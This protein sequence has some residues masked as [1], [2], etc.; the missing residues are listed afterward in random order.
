MK[1]LRSTRVRSKPDAGSRSEIHLS[2]GTSE[3]QR[4]R[5][6]KKYDRGRTNFEEITGTSLDLAHEV[7]V[8][9]TQR[10]LESSDSN[11]I[12]SLASV[13][14]FNLAGRYNP[15]SR[16]ATPRG[17]ANIP[18]IRPVLVT[19]RHTKRG[20]IEKRRAALRDD[21]RNQLGRQM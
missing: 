21:A 1:G 7:P 4:S 20:G 10:D 14:C 8:A 19:T 12:C 18:T 9:K 2:E 15:G 6:N 16:A 5:H 3:I 17:F 11:A 13:I